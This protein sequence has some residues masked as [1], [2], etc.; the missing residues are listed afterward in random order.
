M[1]SNL[2]AVIRWFPSQKQAIEERAARDE[3]I[4]GDGSRIGCKLQYSSRHEPRMFPKANQ[5]FA[6]SGKK[7]GSAGGASCAS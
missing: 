2:A 6:A 5:Y 3:L 7:L 4:L 1:S